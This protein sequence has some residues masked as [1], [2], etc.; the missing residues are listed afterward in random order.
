M[1]E[2]ISTQGL[3][4]LELVKQIGWPYHGRTVAEFYSGTLSKR[5]LEGHSWATEAAPLEQLSHYPIRVSNPSSP[6][7]GY[8]F[9]YGL[10]AQPIGLGNGENPAAYSSTGRGMQLLGVPLKVGGEVLNLAVFHNSA[11]SLTLYDVKRGLYR[12][13][14]F[15]FPMSSQNRFAVYD[16]Y[17]AARVVSLAELVSLDGAYP[18]LKTRVLDFYENKCL[19]SIEPTRFCDSLASIPD[20]LDHNYLSKEISQNYTYE[21]G[22]NVITVVEL[23]ASGTGLGS[24]SINVVYGPSATSGDVV[25]SSP[26]IA[27]VQPNGD[28]SY[29]WSTSVTNAVLDAWYNELGVIQTLRG[30]FSHKRTAKTVGRTIYN[31]PQTF[32]VLHESE[33]ALSGPSGSAAEKLKHEWD[34]FFG[35]SDNVKCKIW[36]NDVLIS[37]EV[38]F[39]FNARQWNVKEPTERAPW[40]GDECRMLTLGY[41]LTYSDQLGAGG[42]MPQHYT[43]AYRNNGSCSS[44]LHAITENYY[45]DQNIPM[46]KTIHAGR[47]LSKYGAVN[48]EAFSDTV[49]LDDPR[50]VRHGTNVWHMRG[51]VGALT[52]QILNPITGD[53]SGGSV[54]HPIAHYNFR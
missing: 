35:S 37:D 8:H 12:N 5:E 42:F 40:P 39:D 27:T 36:R 23:V 20:D 41:V 43:V 14:T 54:E 50:Y 28:T 24:V 51:Y 48:T 3:M 21:H 1:L 18:V 4:G 46:Q 47:V 13:I 32:N 29:T 9:L 11:G 16:T 33:V 52:R 10:D 34:W 7:W 17:G 49:Y 44:S 25:R 53:P 6:E 31:S 45:R 2:P 15:A 38:G 19:V 22:R 26:A 30:S